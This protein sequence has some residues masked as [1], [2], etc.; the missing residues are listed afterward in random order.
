LLS[1]LLVGD[2]ITELGDDATPVSV[3]FQGRRL[4]PVDDLVVS[5]SAREEERRVSIGVRRA[6]D[7]TKSDKKTARLL[8]AYVQMAADRWQGITDGRWRLYLAVAVPSPAVSQLRE[9]TV[10]ARAAADEA[11]FRTEVELPGRADRDVRSRLVHVDALIASAA[12]QAGTA[13]ADIDAAVL[14]WRVLHC[15][16]V[17]VLRLEGGDFAD[18]THAVS[19]LRLLTADGTAAAGDDLFARIAGLAGQ[20]ASTGAKVSADQ[21]R[22]DLGTPLLHARP[23]SRPSVSAGAMLRGPVAHLGL[24]QQHGFSTRSG[25]DGK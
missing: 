15:L 18:R 16:K 13:A 17:R 21:L 4:S 8:A 19:R 3:R 25:N 9:L 2:P 14:T 6:P 24:A 5:G 20:Y 22:E 11:E 1:S 23:R 10:I 12:K 7:L